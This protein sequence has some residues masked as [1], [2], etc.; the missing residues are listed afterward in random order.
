MCVIVMFIRCVSE[1]NNGDYSREWA[2][3]KRFVLNSMKQFGYASGTLE[4][5]LTEEIKCLLDEL[6]QLAASPVDPRQVM[7]KA[8]A[9]V[10]F[11]ILINK[12]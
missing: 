5:K 9:N 3:N 1:L 12:R 10:I 4:E 11:S 7:S 2:K 8:M 6:G